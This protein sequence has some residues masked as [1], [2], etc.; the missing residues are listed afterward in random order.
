MHRALLKKTLNNVQGA[1]VFG[2]CTLNTIFWVLPLMVLAVFKLIVPIKSFR[3][4]MTRWIMAIGEIWVDCMAVI[5]AAVN[6]TRWEVTGLEEL[7]NDDWYLIVAN[8][9][10]WVDIIALQ[11]VFNR[12][13]PFLKFFIKQELIWFPFLGMA[14]WGLDMPFMTAQERQG[15]RGNQKS[16]RKISPYTHVGDQLHRRH[17]IYRGQKGQTCIAVYAPATATGRR[18]GA[19]AGFD[20][21]DVHRDSR[22][23]DRVPRRGTGI[24]DVVL[25]RIRPYRD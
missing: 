8:H 4:L 21:F 24:P 10:T 22:H 17:A 23:H 3:T 14:W 13:V 7:S 9:Q 2:A 11:K 5:F 18:H 19:G 12:R 20:G 15:P 6:T 25:R 16:L 1:L